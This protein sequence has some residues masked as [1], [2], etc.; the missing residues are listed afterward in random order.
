VSSIDAFYV[1]QLET[2]P[3]TAEMI[4]KNTRSLLTQS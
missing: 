4:R 3:V 2:L 1:N